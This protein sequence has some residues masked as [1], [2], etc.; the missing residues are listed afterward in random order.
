VTFDPEGLLSTH[1]AIATLMIG[2]IAGEWFTNEAFPGSESTLRWWQRESFSALLGLA[3][4]RCF[5][6]IRSS[7]LA[8]GACCSARGQPAR[9]FCSYIRSRYQGWRWWAAPALVFGTNCDLR[10]ALSNCITTLADRI[11]WN[12]ASG[13]T[14]TLHEWA[15]AMRFATWLSPVHASLR[16]CNHR[17]FSSTL[18][19]S[20]RFITS[21]YSCGSEEKRM[22]CRTTLDH[23]HYYPVRRK[24]DLERF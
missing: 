4:L 7:G 8:L 6:S 10:F 19:S 13:D 22:Y 11:H 15:T 17:L 3:A 5:P 12:L 24:T 20:I 18:R 16:V 21:R 23:V 2:M 14:L 1:S 9:V